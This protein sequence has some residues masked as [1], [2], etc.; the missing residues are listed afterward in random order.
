[1][2]KQHPKNVTVLNQLG[3]LALQ[4]KQYDKALERLEAAIQLEP[5]NKNTNCLLATVYQETG[6]QAKADEY[7]KKCVN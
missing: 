2:N 7:N 1:L 3:R 6:N 4:T 5:D